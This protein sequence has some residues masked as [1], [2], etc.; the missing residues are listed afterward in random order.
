ASI[1]RIPAPARLAESIPLGRHAAAVHGARDAVRLVLAGTD[2]RLLVIAGPCSV[3]DPS[4]A[5]EY[6]CWLAEQAAEFG[7]DLLLV[8]RAYGEK[9]GTAGGW[10]GLVADPW[11]DGS[12]DMVAGLDAARA[13]LIELAMLEV[14]VATE[15][16]DPRV[17]PYL[18]DCVTFG[19]IG[20]RTT[21]SQPH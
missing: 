17:V 7:D 18:E 2:D 14:P 10:R 16:V 13:L 19:M 11:L 12:C 9:P 15:W 21:Q 1:D 6:A 5:Q 8:M 3:H 4:A 20:A